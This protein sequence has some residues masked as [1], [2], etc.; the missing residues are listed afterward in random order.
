MALCVARLGTLALVLSVPLAGCTPPDPG[1][2][3]GV[4]DAGVPD[5]G[6]LDAGGNAAWPNEPAGSES[7]TERPFTATV[8]DGW[9]TPLG[10][11]SVVD[12]PT[13]PRSSVSVGQ[14]S[15]PANFNGGS[16][17]ARLE[18][19]FSRRVET[20]Y[21]SFWIKLSS[22]FSGHP[23]GVN[24]ILH[25]WIN[26]G[27][28]LYLTAQGS[29]SGALLS[30]VN[31]QGVIVSGGAVNLPPNLVPTAQLT[32]GQWHRWEIVI[33]ANTQ[34][35][36]NGTVDWWLDGAHVGSVNDVAFVG[37]M[38]ERTWE[39]LQW[40]PTWGGIGSTVPAEQFMWID[41]LYASGR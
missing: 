35:L 26:G 22:N 10:T 36:P 4:T 37:A 39:L 29:G 34:G 38:D 17:P 30:Q 3:A 11:F 28:R 32:R 2:D 8:E 16:E 40:A 18:K 23:T 25:F 15:Y 19:S 12:D 1:S 24:K 20:I 13:A 33:R 21:T 9:L 31:L 6:A 7:L 5:A 27:N 41:H 14:V